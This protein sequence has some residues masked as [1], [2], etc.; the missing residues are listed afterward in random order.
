MFKKFTNERVKI[1]CL[2]NTSQIIVKSIVTTGVNGNKN[3]CTGV[4]GYKNNCNAT[5]TKSWVQNLANLVS[6]ALLY[7]FHDI[8]TG[9]KLCKYGKLVKFQKTYKSYL[10]VFYTNHDK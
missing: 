9:R 3:S 7:Y 2:C 10:K 5:E 4:N 6:H 8:L 1:M